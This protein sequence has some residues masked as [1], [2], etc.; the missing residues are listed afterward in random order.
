MRVYLTCPRL[1][2]NYRFSLS[3]KALPRSHSACLL[4]L[5]FFTCLHKAGEINLIQA[6]TFLHRRA[7]RRGIQPV[8]CFHYAARGA[9]LLTLSFIYT[10]NR[11]DGV[12]SWG[13]PSTQ[14]S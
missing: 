14:T 3:F 11:E 10:L 8:Q 4:D 9:N 1:Y 13:Q 5:F 12:G 2:L 7:A 6:M